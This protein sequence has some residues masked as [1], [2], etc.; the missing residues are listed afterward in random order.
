MFGGLAKR[1]S[2]S[3]LNPE[4]PKTNI[5]YLCLNTFIIN[6]CTIQ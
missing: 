2:N 5:I 6:T 4:L 3:N 1:P